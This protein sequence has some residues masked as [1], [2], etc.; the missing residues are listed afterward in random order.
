[1]RITSRITS[2]YR[3]PDYRGLGR[4]RAI[5]AKRRSE[6][7]GRWRVKQRGGVGDFLSIGRMPIAPA[8]AAASLKTHFTTLAAAQG[9]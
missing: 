9:F 5:E 4:G 8:L 1:M 6:R 2:T 7:N 3:A